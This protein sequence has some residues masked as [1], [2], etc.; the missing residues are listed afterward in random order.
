MQSVSKATPARVG[1]FRMGIDAQLHVAKAR[2]KDSSN[3]FNRPN[4]TLKL[5]RTPQQPPTFASFEVPLNMNK[6]DLRDYLWNAYGVQVLGVRSYIQQ[7][8]VR[9]DKPG[10]KRIQPR[11]WYR[12][13]AIKRML[14]ELEKPFVWPEVP[15][16]FDEYVSLLLSLFYD[17]LHE[18]EK[19]TFD[20]AQ[21]DRKSNSEMYE[22]GFREKPAKDRKS[23][24]EQAKAILK[25]EASWKPNQV[26]EQWENDGEAVEVEQGLDLPKLEDK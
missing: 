3:A 5:L 20:A 21:E 17:W 13:R 15:E 11:K 23:I 4:F 22:P 25:G 7:Q 2:T 16:N 9:Q 6:L 24:A 26:R 12:P 14:V 10:A 18:W 1:R 8:K 19:D